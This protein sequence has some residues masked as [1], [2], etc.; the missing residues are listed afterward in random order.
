MT[1]LSDAALARLSNDAY[2]DTPVALPAGFTPLDPSTIGITLAPGE[3]F[4]N[5]IF[6]SGNAAALLSVAV[7]DG[8]PTIVLAF[9][10]SD[11]ATDSQQDLT[12]INASY[13]E[14]ASLVAAV[15][16]ASAA[17]GDPVVVTGHSLGGAMAQLYMETHPDQPNAPDHAAVT[18]GSPGALLPAGTDDRITNYVIADDPAVVLGAHRADIGAALRTDPTLADLAA[19]QAARDFP[20]LTAAEAKAA[21]TT[22]TANYDNHGHFVVLPGVDGRTDPA[23]DI[24]NLARVDATRHAPDLYATELAQYAAGGPAVL[25]PE[26]ASTDPR[27][28]LLQALYDGS[29]NDPAARSAGFAALLDTYVAT[30]GNDL[31]HQAQHAL[32]GIGHDL[33]LI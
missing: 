3:T 4:S 7:L 22:L 12:N 5:G 26:A 11:D 32:A 14:F 6:H 23:A 33:Q 19:N 16:H 29:A 15:D 1:P 24:A 28:H 31:L 10:G 25:V 9:R 13:G 30:H 17:W 2:A 18:F 21:L 20:G 8:L 27:L